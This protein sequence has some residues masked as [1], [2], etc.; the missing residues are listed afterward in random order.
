ML[1]HIGTKGGTRPYRNPH[2][3][4]EVVASL[5]STGGGGSDPT[6]LVEHVHAEPV[7]NN[8]MNTPNSWMAVDLGA[9]RS[10]LPAHYCLRSANQ[11]GSHKLRHWR[12]E[13]SN[14]GNEWTTLR[15]HTGNASL[16]TESMSV[17]AWPLEP[18]TV[19][20]RSFRHFRIVQTGKNSSNYDF[21]MCT[22]I[23]LYGVF[24]DRE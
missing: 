5:S 14:D 23:E 11:S 6:R 4:G 20:G 17:A 12:L 16:S 13:A 15:H 22:G 2:A 10:L 19:Q 7:H 1:Y 3:S 8:T 24:R 18:A 21:L 9:G